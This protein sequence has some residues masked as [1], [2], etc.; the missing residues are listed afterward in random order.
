MA[1]Q[2]QSEITGTHSIDRRTIL[3]GNPFQNR[4]RAKSCSTHSMPTH[5]NVLGERKRTHSMA[6]MMTATEVVTGM[7]SA[8][9]G[10]S[11]EE[12]GPLASR[13]PQGTH[14]FQAEHPAGTEWSE[15]C[16]LPSLLVSPRYS[17]IRHNSNCMFKSSARV[18]FLRLSNFWEW[19]GFLSSNNS[20]LLLATCRRSG[21]RLQS[22]LASPSLLLAILGAEISYCLPYASL[23]TSLPRW[24]DF[25]KKYIAI[26]DSTPVMWAVSQRCCDCN[27]TMA[28]WPHTD[29]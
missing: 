5:W 11:R 7:W 16:H 14:T 6:V 8:H 12:E 20:F 26:H 15:L 29:L 27:E 10:S 17:T 2:S 25:P 19:W 1:I 22:S 23:Q 18:C 9:S 28:L 3:Y 13:S 21:L 4:G 24:S